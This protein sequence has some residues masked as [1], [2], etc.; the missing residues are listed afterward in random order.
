MR[1]VLIESLSI[2]NLICF[3]RPFHPISVTAH[4]I[5]II[6]VI[7]SPIE[8]VFS[9]TENRTRDMK[10]NK[11]SNLLNVKLLVNLAVSYLL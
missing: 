10:S 9:S 6:S 8:G 11:R 3:K 5:L 7:S 4:S 1:R 2:I